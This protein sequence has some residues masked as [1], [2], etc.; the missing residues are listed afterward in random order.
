MEVIISRTK[1]KIL[2]MFGSW[3]GMRIPIIN[4]E[5]I[6]TGTKDII[7]TMLLIRRVVFNYLYFPRLVSI[8]FFS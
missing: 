5:D 7:I 3:C 1:L 6:C 4:L 2:V 8:E